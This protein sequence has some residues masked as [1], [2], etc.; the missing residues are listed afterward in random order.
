MAAAGG[1]RALPSRRPGLGGAARICRWYWS[2][3][4]KGLPR[5]FKEQITT[6]PST[7]AVD[8]V[9]TA[10]LIL[11]TVPLRPLSPLC[12]QSTYMYTIYIH[13]ISTQSF[14]WKFREIYSIRKK[15]AFLRVY[16]KWGGRGVCHRLYIQYVKMKSKKIRIK[17]K[18]FQ[19]LRAGYARL[20]YTNILW[21]KMIVNSNFY[22]ILLRQCVHYVL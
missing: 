15:S 20:I 3:A 18:K 4:Q 19:F 8:A 14:H 12:G 2:G 11:Y 7:A 10:P 17:K 22:F 16:T 1:A 6:L 21:I 5:P 9:S 13:R